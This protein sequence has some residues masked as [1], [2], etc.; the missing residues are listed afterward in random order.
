MQTSLTMD[1]EF[2]L[3]R[4]KHCSMTFNDPEQLYIHLTNDHVGRKSTGNLCLTCGWENCDVTVI[5]RDHITSH[6]R[7]HVPLKPHRCQFCS[8]SFKRPQ[9]LKKH[10]KIHS[11]QHIS[12]LRSYQRAHHNQQHPLTP[13]NSI[14]HSSRDVSPILSDHHPISPPT[15]T[16]SDENW[17]YAGVS[18]TTAR[19]DV[20][21]AYNN[22][23]FQNPVNTSQPPQLI[24]QDPQSNFIS[25]P[26]DKNYEPDQIIHDL[27]F[28]LEMNST[29]PTAEYNSS[30]ANNL[31]QI[32][33]FLEA[34]TINQSNFN[35]NINTEQQ[36][37]DM[38]DWLARLSNSIATGQMPQ[39]PSTSTL[40]YNQLSTFT[41]PLQ[42][43]QYP[44]MIPSQ[45]N[46]H[47]VSSSE[48]NDIYVRSQPMPQPVVPSQNINELNNTYLGQP[49][50][51]QIYYQ[52]QPLPP[53][54]HYQQNIGLT[55]QRQHYTAVPN[56]ANNFFQPELRT[57]TNYTRANYPENG[58]TEKQETVSFKP[59]K[60]VTHDE[61]KNM[62][63]LIN[64]FSSALVEN[65]KQPTRVE[66]EEK[67]EPE[68]K[69]E[70]TIRELITSDLSKLSLNDNNS[71]E[72]RKDDLAITNAKDSNPS[73]SSLYPI[74][75]EKR[76]VH[77][78][79]NHL[80]LVQKMKQWVNEN[81]RKNHPS[82]KA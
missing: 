67:N 12:S 50:A 10:E 17:M 57:A 75:N 3:C 21:M 2:F 47:L 41:P 81:Y 68:T 30:V 74:T 60:S 80:L 64:T 16:Y 15:S 4:W 46:V 32:Q 56:V 8:K 69:P 42:Q 51:N 49:L 36:L 59:T 22:D 28:P 5:K 20:S 39:E 34:G 63:T 33:S 19:S 45:N 65:K 61:K 54:Q 14:Q 13:P 53:Q 31:D 82:L 27:F 48:E 18:P 52:Q 70:N 72:A 79:K 38:N 11:E 43:S 55:G 26:I 9:D 62:A 40:G 24:P 29:K 44:V 73:S 37:Q 6:L 58:E 7:V 71:S 23:Y 76:T 1:N 77:I 35:L 66:K 25:Q 78:N